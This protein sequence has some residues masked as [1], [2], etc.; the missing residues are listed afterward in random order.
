MMEV[1]T[2]KNNDK[3][4]KV[5]VIFLLLFCECAPA[6]RKKAMI[7]PERLNYLLITKIEQHF[8]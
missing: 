3:L 1:L 5:S 8:L 2:E 6:K 7:I 4:D